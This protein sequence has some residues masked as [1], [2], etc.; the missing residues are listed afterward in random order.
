[1][2]FF[3]IIIKNIFPTKYLAI[4]YIYWFNPE[5]MTDIPMKGFPSELK[6]FIDN[7]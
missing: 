7:Q 3:I 1:V 4:H 6:V 2:A 5:P